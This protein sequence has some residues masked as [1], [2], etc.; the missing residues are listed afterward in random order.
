M[1]ATDLS[2]SLRKA[3]VIVAHPDDEI[4]WC[5][6]TILMNPD[7]QWTVLVLCRGNDADRAPKFYR[8]LK[9]ETKEII[10]NYFISICCWQS[11]LY[12]R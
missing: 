10:D 5:G 12:G 11:G 2:N 8:V 4:I 9:N 7:L 1:N 3:A 6:G